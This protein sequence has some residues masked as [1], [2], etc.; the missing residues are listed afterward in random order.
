MGDD[1]SDRFGRDIDAS[2]ELL[3][4]S[5]DAWGEIVE[6]LTDLVFH[7]IEG[8]VADGTLRSPALVYEEL[9]EGDDDLVDWARDQRKSGMFF[10]D[11]DEQVQSV[12]SEVADFVEQTYE[13][14]QAKLFLDGADPWVIACAK[15]QGG[16]VVTFEVSAP[17]AR[18]VKIPDVSSHFSVTCVNTYKMLR[19]LGAKF[20]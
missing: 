18:K 16:V 12:M 13:S 8:K 20:R 9:V 6:A 2:V 3:Q 19:D 7:A 4:R 1:A 14:S 17:A 11:P 15:A 5:S 10:V